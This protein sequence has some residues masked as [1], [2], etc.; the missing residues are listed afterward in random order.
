MFVDTWRNRV[1]NYKYWDIH[2]CSSIGGFLG[3]NNQVFNTGKVFVDR[4]FFLE[5][6]SK[7]LLHLL[8]LL[9]VYLGVLEE[10]MALSFSLNLVIC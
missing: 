6:T 3:R 1:K 2:K 4:R 8:G 5:E 9:P 10:N 7:C